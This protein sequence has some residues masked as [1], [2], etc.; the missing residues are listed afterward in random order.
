M[1]APQHPAGPV[2][3][4]LTGE[5]PPLMGGVADYTAAVA[6]ALAA[7]GV[8][9]HVWTPRAGRSRLESSHVFTSND[10][11][12]TRGRVLVEE[13]GDGWSPRSLRRLAARLDA[14]PAPRRLLVQW[15]PNAWGWK[16]MNLAFC[17][18]LLA[19]RRRGDDVRVMVHEVRYTLESSDGPARRVLAGVQRLMVATLMR[20]ATRV[21]VAI[22]AWA[23]RLCRDAPRSRP[24]VVWRPVPN[25]IPRVDN[26][27]QVARRRLDLA[28]AGA[29]IVGC[30]ATCRGEVAAQLGQILPRVLDAQPSCVALVIGRGAAAFVDDLNARRPRLAGRLN[31]SDAVPA[32]S[33]SIDLQAC[34]LMLQPYP[35]GVSTRRTTIMAPLAHGVPAVTK[36]GRLSEPFWSTIQPVAL[37]PAH[38]PDAFVARA[39]ELLDSH[40]E[41]VAIARRGLRLYERCFA[42]ERTVEALLSNAPT[43]PDPVAALAEPEPEA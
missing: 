10:L 38:D 37:A 22:P 32:A 23:D 35:D 28:P 8:E 5:Y 29:A 24:P 39:L 25:T 42:V 31:A 9:V 33:I 15:T 2:L 20:A 43:P 41:R 18:F 14:F 12:A 26:P 40:A 36:L 34:D 13:F 30:F 1:S 7:R 3:H 16:G 19:R 17:R 11:D 6:S 21:D 4:I 27:A